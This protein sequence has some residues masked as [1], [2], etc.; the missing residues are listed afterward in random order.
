MYGDSTTWGSDGSPDQTTSEPEW[1]RQVVPSHV[2]IANHGVR[3]ATAAQLYNGSDGQH[4]PWPQQMA[5]STAEII[6]L[7]YALND[8][9][10]VSLQDYGTA[11]RALIDVAKGTGKIVVLQ[12]PNPS[13]DPAMVALPLYVKALN[14]IAVEKGVRVVHQYGAYA[15]W[16]AHETDCTHPDRDY[17]KIKAQSTYGAIRDLL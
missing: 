11:I 17:Y 14:E 4:L 12:E 9:A 6:T 2:T 10:R 5:N 15:D 13:C 1:L 3:G 8:S 16:K 7:N